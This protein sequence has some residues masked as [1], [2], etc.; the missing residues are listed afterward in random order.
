MKFELKHSFACDP[1]TLWEITDGDEFEQRLG[2]MSDTDRTLHEQRVQGGE[3][4]TRR[5]ITARRQLPAAMVKVLGSDQIRYDQETWRPTD[6]SG[7]LRWKITPMVLQGRF[8]GSGTTVV[9]K[10]A[11]GCERII[12]GELTIRV[13]LVGGQMEKKLVE[14]VS[15]S[16]DRAARVIEEMLRERGRA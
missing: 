11:S 1:Q 2:K 9:R 3:R 16:Y 5:T 15:T 6:G 13:P 7:P 10:T 12:A 4:Y 14:D 8:E